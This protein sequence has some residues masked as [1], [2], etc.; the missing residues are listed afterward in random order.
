MNGRVLEI[1]NKFVQEVKSTT[2]WKQSDT[3]WENLI[4]TLPW[5][6]K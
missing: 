5:V 4:Q 2:N 1:M 3:V 6:I